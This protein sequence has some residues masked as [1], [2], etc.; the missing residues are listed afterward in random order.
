SMQSMGL[1]STYRRCY[2]A[3]I[4]L[5]VTLSLAAMACACNVPVFRFA[6][7]RWRPYVYRVTLLHRGPLSEAQREI[8]R[9]LQEA[10]EKGLANFVLQVVDVNELEKPGDS[11]SG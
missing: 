7:E 8:A 6:L 3:A 4:A 5:G 10:Q 11:N 9:P 2:F 1:L